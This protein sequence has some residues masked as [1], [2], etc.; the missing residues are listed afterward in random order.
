MQ[1]IIPNCTWE[2]FLRRVDISKLS[3]VEQQWKRNLERSRPY[4]KSTQTKIPPFRLVHQVAHALCLRVYNTWIWNLTSASFTSASATDVDF[5]KRRHQ[6]YQLVKQY[7]SPEKRLVIRRWTIGG[8][9]TSLVR[10]KWLVI[11][12]S[13]RRY[14]GQ[15]LR[16]TLCDREV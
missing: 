3:G 10:K 1:R 5:I 14:T 15:N 7:H 16:G 9:I 11:L 4:F 8:K 12:S 2:N 6:S 13:L